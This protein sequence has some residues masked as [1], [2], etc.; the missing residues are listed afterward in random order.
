MVVHIANDMY[1]L[2]DRFI[3]ISDQLG[4]LHVTV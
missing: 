4:G 2:R 1:N 3:H